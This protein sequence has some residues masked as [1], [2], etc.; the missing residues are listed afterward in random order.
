MSRSFL[1]GV[2]LFC[3]VFAALV[4]LVVLSRSDDEAPAARRPAPA[5]AAQTATATPAG[6]LEGA[7]ERIATA[8]LD[9]HL[10]ALQHIAREHDG[11]RSA[12]TEGERET[13]AYI[14]RTLRAAGYR[15]STQAV[16]V[17]T[18]E[19]R[20]RPR[21]TAGGRAFE[22]RSFR[23]SGSGTVTGT[24]RR[25]SAPLGCTAR[26]YAD[27]GRGG[28]ALARRGTC[29]FRVKALAAQRA[30][31]AALLVADTRLVRGGTLARAGVRIPVLAVSA[32]TAEAVAGER[33][34]L[35]VDATTSTRP[36]V[37]VLAEA[38]AAGAPRV[39]MAGGH[40]D[41]VPEGPGLNDNGSGVAALLETAQA[42]GGGRPLPD[43]TALR[44]GFWGAEEVG[45]VGSRRYVE[46]L[47][48]AE[49]ARVAA[50]VNLDM[51][52]TPAETP[53]VYDGDEAIQAALR[54][55]LGER[56]PERDLG[57]SSDHASF[58]AADIPVG[59]IS[60]GLDACYHQRCDTLDNVDRRVLTRSAKAA[61][62][63]L[64]TLLRG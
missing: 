42:L 24:V 40:L 14:A 23:F 52:G 54:A 32:A 53:A 41:S 44:F 36:S 35:R 61:G 1:R 55:Q 18:F 15:V 60:T 20:S 59:G 4:V 50:Y 37:N 31:A 46:G 3:V 57:G 26:A 16:P 39:V 22:V 51:V 6:P 7:E 34:R 11:N 8:G 5:A 27:V 25:T 30:G 10:Q 13:A 56:A 64:V 29:A 17:T 62:G 38:G 12:G 43:G 28:V 47:S 45:L 21:L 58:A 19:E 2:V 9:A 63:A 33:V 49:R 48:G